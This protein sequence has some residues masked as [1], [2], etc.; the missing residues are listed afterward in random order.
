[1]RLRALIFSLFVIFISGVGWAQ[2]TISEG[3]W[4]DPGIWDTGLV[5]SSADGAI[6][7]EHAVTIPTGYVLSLDQAT[8]TPDGYLTIENGATVTIVNGTGVD[9]SIQG[10]MDVYGTLINAD[11]AVIDGTDGTNLN[12]FNGST[13]TWQYTTT[14][15]TPP[16]A[17][18]EE[19]S[20]LNITGYTTARTLSNP[21]WSQN[22]GNIIWNCTAQ[23]GAINWGEL[24]T[25]I[26]G[27]LTVASTGSQLIRFSDA[28]DLTMQITGDLNISGTARIN[29]ARSAAFT[30]VDIG[31]D[32]NYTSTNSGGSFTTLSGTALVNIA[33]NLVINAGASGRLRLGS[34]GT[35]N[36]EIALG[37]DLLISAGILDEGGASTFGTLTFNSGGGKVHTFTN[38]AASN[39]P[40]T[41]SITVGPDDVLDVGASSMVTGVNGTG[42]NCTFTVEGTLR[43][44]STDASGAIRN[45]TNGGNIRTPTAGRVYVDGSTIVYNGTAAQFIGNG[46]PTNNVNVVINNSNGV[47]LATTSVT[48]GGDLTLQSG[49]LNVASVASQRALVL[50]G[51]VTANGNFI[52]YSGTLSDLTING[53]GNL[54]TFPFPTGAQTMRNFILNRSG[55]SVTFDNNLTITGTVSLQA[56]EMIFNNRTLSLNGTFA[57]TGGFLSSNNA[58]TLNVGGSGSFGT[59]V[60]S[61]T[62]NNLNTLNFNRAGVGS[63]TVDGTLVITSALNLNAGDLTNNAGLTLSNGAT[64][65]RN[66]GAQLLSN[67]PSNSPGDAYNVI[68]T[69]SSLTTGLELP[70]PADAQ[71][72][73]NLTIN[74]GP[75]TLNQNIIINGDLNINNSTFNG[76]S[77]TITMQGANWNDNSGNFTTGTSTVIFNGVT[78]VGGSS[79]PT[80]GNIQLNNS[81]TVIFPTSNVNVSGDIQINAGGTFNANN[82]TITLI[83]GNLQTIAGAGSTFHNLT[84]N[85]SAGVNVQLS[86][87]LNLT[88]A[89]NILST[90]TFTSG[91]LL[92]LISTSDGTSGN[93]SIASIPSGASVSGNVTVQRFMSSEGRIWRYI[94]S[95]ITNATVAQLQDD[96]PVTGKF[97]GASTCTGCVATSPSMYIYNAATSAYVAFPSTTNTEQLVPGRGYSPYIR[98]DVLAG[99]VTIDYTGPINQ[100]ALALPVAF[101]AA[102]AESWNLVGN[103]YPSSIDWDIIA[104]WTKT[105]ISGTVAVRDNGSGGVFS[106]WDGATGSLSNGEI[107]AGQGF[108]VRATAASPALSINEQAKTNV[109]GA[110][111]REESPVAQDVFSIQLKSNFNNLLYDQAY[112]RVRP[113]SN[114]NLDI[115]DAPKLKNDYLNFASVEPNK[116][117]LAINA[118]PTLYCGMTIPFDLVFEKGSNGAFLQRPYGNFTF[119]FDFTGQWEAYQMVWKDAFAGT[120]RVITSGDQ[121]TF[122]VTT[123]A[124]SFA[125]DRFSLV[126]EERAPTTNLTVSLGDRVCEGQSI[127]LTISQSEYHVAYQVWANDSLFVTIPG[128]G[129]ISTNLPSALFNAEINLVKVIAIS[130]CGQPYDI[131]TRTI[132]VAPLPQVAG[133]SAKICG[134]GNI[135]LAVSSNNSVVSYN[136]YADEKDKNPLSFHGA[137]LTIENIQRTQTYYVSGITA[138]GCE[139]SRVPV[140]AE[141]AY[142]IVPAVTWK[143]D[144]L[145]S[146]QREGL[147]WYRNGVII[148]G[149]TD[150]RYVPSQSGSYYVMVSQNDCQVKSNEY[151]Y[152]EVRDDG[153][154]L[155]AKLVSLYPNPLEGT[156]VVTLEIPGEGGYQ[157]ALYNNQGVKV[158]DVALHDADNGQY[159][160]LDLS[161]V[162]AGLYFVRV[163][164]HGNSTVI[165]LSKE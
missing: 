144:A 22:Y 41:I 139:G 31:G 47:S 10:L 114:E 117:S 105:N 155:N 120:Q 60:F 54:G 76:G 145:E 153:V 142:A 29:M 132:T 9:L 46:H 24:I 52:T 113:A 160:Y 72:L 102:A 110:F 82:G 57:S 165:K 1:M 83:N 42:V 147:Q 62:G 164:G 87:A 25:V 156:R 101:N 11:L 58:S 140:I 18:W 92:T 78:T 14:E 2:T 48:I 37:G 44:G 67:R 95:P 4:D 146:D 64:V 86:S 118:L 28:A 106:Y 7:I 59:F 13:F 93:A 116:K 19:N 68:Y 133:Q 94:S 39:M 21:N 81:R 85:K 30:Q 66:S 97:T 154:R 129:E 128:G 111:M 50:G 15:G 134:P 148:P 99:P 3:A 69:G 74:G 35:G 151:N 137:T 33:G 127:P 84:I 107:A 157:A 27:D 108:W 36:T 109:T 112:V 5:P 131:T 135:V 23:T 161:D 121:I 38:P 61:N 71:D 88:G 100:G 73:N 20:T 34:S 90:S 17:F 16:L 49:N 104:G 122:A 70:N 163:E 75:V 79:E 51:D 123:D 43:V 130:L 152:L 32:L 26:G 126:L 89:L 63:A 65:T 6:S 149:A 56:G 77:F 150:Y 80:F 91:G 124:R 162:P 45:V 158:A 53:T 103:P 40:G 141:V 96:F 136:W 115:Y 125:A 55:G 143:A 8:I 119:T 138:D 12:F 159:G 98:Q